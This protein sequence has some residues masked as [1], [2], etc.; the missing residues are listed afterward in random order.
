MVTR[1]ANDWKNN[2][3]R[4]ILSGF[5]TDP[6]AFFEDVGFLSLLNYQLI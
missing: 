4:R 6:H 3:F 5:G 2:W 1:F